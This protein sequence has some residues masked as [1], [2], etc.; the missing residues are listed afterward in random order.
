MLEVALLKRSKCGVLT[1]A[2]LTES[3]TVGELDFLKV[4]PVLPDSQKRNLP[5]ICRKCQIEMRELWN[6]F[7]VALF[8]AYIP[9]LLNIGK[10][11]FRNCRGKNRKKFLRENE[12]TF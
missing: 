12:K 2:T 11:E 3:R 6:K 1:P 4:H 8:C 9:N 10:V 5:K 7:L